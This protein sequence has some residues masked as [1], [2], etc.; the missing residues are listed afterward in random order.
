M[1]LRFSFCVSNSVSNLP[2]SLVLAAFLSGP[3][4]PTHYSQGWVL[5]KAVGIIGV[6]VSSEAVD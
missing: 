2:I 1:P 5:G 3:F 6:V 4:Q